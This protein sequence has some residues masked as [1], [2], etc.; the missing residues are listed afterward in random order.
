MARPQIL[1]Y[2]NQ[3]LRP[4]TSIESNAIRYM[5]RYV[6]FTLHKRN[7]KPTKNHELKEK[8]P[9][10]VKILEK[11]KTSDL[12]GE[13]DTIH[14]YTRLWSELIDRGGLY[15]INDK[16]CNG[17]IISLTCAVFLF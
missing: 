2:G 11:M 13:V 6:V 1:N 8:Q 5:A 12:H 4:H 10:C 15:H 14:E 17:Q 16:V 3:Q 7:R 9:V